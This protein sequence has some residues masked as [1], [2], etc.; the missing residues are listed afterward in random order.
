MHAHAFMHAEHM[1]VIY[2]YEDLTQYL[3]DNF[4]MKKKKDISFDSSHLSSEV[5]ITTPVSLT[6]H[7]L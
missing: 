5:A 1:H 6:V 3:Y 2:H 4:S 7:T